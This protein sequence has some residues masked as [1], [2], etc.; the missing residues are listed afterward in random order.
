[1][2][3][4]GPSIRN[5]LI[6][7][8]SIEYIY[9]HGL[10]NLVKIEAHLPKIK[11]RVLR[12]QGKNRFY[13]EALIIKITESRLCFIANVQM[14]AMHCLNAKHTSK[15]VKLFL[16]HVKMIK[17]EEKVLLLPISIASLKLEALKMKY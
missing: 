1:M 7:G 8:Y 16:T 13:L 9:Q 11:K 3:L 4:V 17:A 12:A 10:Y 5:C 15:I 2:I 14:S 6:Y